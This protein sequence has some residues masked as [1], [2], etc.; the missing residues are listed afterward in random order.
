MIQ[1]N[2]LPGTSS[3]SA[4]RSLDIGGMVA[5]ATAGIRDKF[6]TWQGRK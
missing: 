5:G 6:M 4:G 1:V 2:L 3:K